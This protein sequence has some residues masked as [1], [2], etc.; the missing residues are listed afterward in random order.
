MER[1]LETLGFSK[2]KFRVEGE[3][4]LGYYRIEVMGG[5]KKKSE[6]RGGSVTE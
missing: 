6:K 2:T 5:P 4:Y 3:M 1:K